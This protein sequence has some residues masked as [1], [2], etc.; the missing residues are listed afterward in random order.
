MSLVDALVAVLLMVFCV[1]VEWRMDE[2]GKE[3]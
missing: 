2:R 1:A 3:E